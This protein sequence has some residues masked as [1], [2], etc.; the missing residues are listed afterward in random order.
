MIYKVGVVEAF[1]KMISILIPSVLIILLNVKAGRLLFK[2]PFIGVI[3]ILPTTILIYR[4]SLP[5]INGIHSWIDLKS[6]NI[7][8]SE[9]V[10]ET[11]VISKEDV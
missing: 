3:S 11:E 6:E 4:A 1:K 5:L 10:V 9:T 7:V 8:N 2:Y